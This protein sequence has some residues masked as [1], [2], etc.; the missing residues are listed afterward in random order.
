MLADFEEAYAK[1]SNAM[2]HNVFAHTLVISQKEVWSI[3]KHP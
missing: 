2:K 1:P 3:L